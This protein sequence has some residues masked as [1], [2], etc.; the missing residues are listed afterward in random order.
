MTQTEY[1]TRI[2]ELIESAKGIDSDA[3]KAAVKALTEAHSEIIRSLAAL[4]ADKDGK[5]SYSR[6]QL[7]QLRRAIERSMDEFDRRMTLETKSAMADQYRAGSGQID[8]M[9]KDAIGVQ[10]ALTVLPSYNLL[11]AQDYT[12]DLVT[13]LSASAKAKLNAVLRRSAL[14][15]QSV[16]SIMRQIGAS[17]GDGEFGKISR[18]AQTIYRTEVSRMGHAAGQARLEEAADR[19]DGLEHQWIHAGYMEKRPRSYHEGIHG[20]HV[21]V[22]EAFP[23]SGPNGEDLMY[24]GDPAGAA[25]DTINCF[26]DVTAWTPAME[27][28]AP[29]AGSKV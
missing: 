22:D 7:D 25:E 18:R 17:I 4:P 8:R 24:P 13:N 12:A 29:L 1:A 26:C 27:K 19:V 14:G 23:G 9:L 3:A 20:M 11:I 16:D 5:V 28:F 10:P 6:F 21:P 15:G 2:R